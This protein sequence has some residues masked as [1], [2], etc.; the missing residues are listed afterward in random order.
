MVPLFIAGFFWYAIFGGVIYVKVVKGSLEDAILWGPVLTL[1]DMQNI[2]YPVLSMRVL[3]LGGH[4]RKIYDFKLEMFFV[5]GTSGHHFNMELHGNANIPVFTSV[6]T[7]FHEINPSSPL[8]GLIES[9]TE[10]GGAYSDSYVHVVIRG[11]DSRVSSYATV[12]Q[13]YLLGKRHKQLRFGRFHVPAFAGV[14]TDAVDSGRLGL[15]FCQIAFAST[16][17][18]S[19]TIPKSWAKE[20]PGASSPRNRRF[21]VH[22]HVPRKM[23]EAHP[24]IRIFDTSSTKRRTM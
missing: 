14:D 6:A 1:S 17:P 4:M 15:K 19:L 20:A 7:I 9:E 10:N 11:E 5:S 2:E 21:S 13:V 16:F 18:T 8:W 24:S 23:L 12:D 22:P 3:N